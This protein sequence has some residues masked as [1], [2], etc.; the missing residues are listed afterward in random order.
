MSCSLAEIEAQAMELSRADRAY[1]L[2]R[3]L[4]SLDKTGGDPEAV[5][6][7]WSDEVQR[8]IDEI[9]SGTVAMRDG[10]NVFAALLGRYRG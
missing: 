7:A 1:L 5:K 4:A 9:D 8:R 6:Q 2:S 10:D 3:L